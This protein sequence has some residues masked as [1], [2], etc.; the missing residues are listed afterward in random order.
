MTPPAMTAD[1]EQV[2]SALEAEVGRLQAEV[3]AAEAYRA[4]VWLNIVTPL[5]ELETHTRAALEQ[6]ATQEALLLKEESEEKAS[7]P[8]D[9]LP[10]AAAEALHNTEPEPT[11]SEPDWAL[12]AQRLLA[13]GTWKIR[14]DSSGQT[15][16]ANTQ[17]KAT[18][19]DLERTLK[20]SAKRKPIIATNSVSGSEA[21]RISEKEDCPEIA[22]ITDE[23]VEE[24]LARVLSAG[25][26]VQKAGANGRPYFFNKKDPRVDKKKT[27][28]HLRPL[29][30]SLLEDA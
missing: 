15:F 3:D 2:V 27:V 22:P 5:L 14:H 30:K 18:T 1:S 4:G 17:T 28:W 6:D 11:P 9:T 21:D 19:W 12:E 10:A 16:F 23:M 20:N 25:L 8:L 7:A 24:E 13:L 29:L 26:W